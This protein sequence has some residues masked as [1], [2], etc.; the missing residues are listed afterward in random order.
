MRSVHEYINPLA[1]KYHD[2]ADAVIAEGAK[3]YMRNQYV[4]FIAG[5]LAGTH[6]N[7]YPELI[8]PVT[9]R[10]MKSGNIWL[11]RSSL[12]FQLKYKN[13]TDTRLM[14]KYIRSLSSSKE[15]FIQ[16]AIGWVL[17]QYSKTDPETVIQFV[18]AHQLPPLS[19]REALKVINRK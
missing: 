9:G 10:W 19:K 13:Q 14:F 2:N 8:K 4:D 5:T 17:R 15:F 11:Q 1:K 3:K 16:K 12:L 18:E 7:L 6:F